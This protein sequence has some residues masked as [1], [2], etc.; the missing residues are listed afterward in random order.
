M[1]GLNEDSEFKLKLTGKDTF[2]PKKK[3]QTNRV[4]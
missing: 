2:G 1:L 4:N 3:E